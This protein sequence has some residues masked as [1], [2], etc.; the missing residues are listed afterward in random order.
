[1][2]ETRRKCKV[3][4]QHRTIAITPI[5]RS[6]ESSS[7]AKALSENLTVSLRR[8]QYPRSVTARGY[9]ASNCDFVTY[10]DTSPAAS[11][12]KPDGR[13]F[14]IEP[15]MKK[16]LL[17]LFV[18]AFVMGSANRSDANLIVNGSFESPGQ[19]TWGLYGDITGWTSGGGNPIEIGRGEVYGVTG[20][21]GSN[22]LELDSTGNATVSQNVTITQAGT[23]QLSFLAGLRAGIDPL[24]QG[25][26]MAFGNLLAF[27][28]PAPAATAMSRY[29]FSINVTTP[30]TYRLSFSGTGTSDSYGAII[31]DVRLN[32]R[33][34][35]DGGATAMLLGLVLAGAG[36]LRR[37]A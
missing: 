3:F 30:G 26:R 34:V 36:V 28:A 9:T 8:R 1:M 31:D 24:S 10:M 35:P 29:M 15:G 32:R 2:V 6:R 33:A 11:V 13:V 19:T 25:F 22:V 27:M 18:V 4:R 37:R 16:L 23:Y 21:E 20:F 14:A 7:R 17:P 5:E 12:P